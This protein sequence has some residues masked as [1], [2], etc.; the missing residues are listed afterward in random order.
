VSPDLSKFLADWH[1]WAT[2][3]AIPGKPSEG[4]FCR[5]FGL[6]YHAE[7]RSTKLYYELRDLLSDQFGQECDTPFNYEIDY[8]QEGDDG[9]MHE[10]PKRLA[11]VRQKLMEEL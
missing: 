11:W 4:G 9:L 3:G 8:W 5:S 7:K 1:D 2:S 10:N 6:C